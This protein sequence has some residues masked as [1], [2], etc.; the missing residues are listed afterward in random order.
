M[1][2][3]RNGTC[4][5]NHKCSCEGET[6]QLQERLRRHSR[7]MPEFLAKVNR[8]REE[9]LRYIVKEE[10]APWVYMQVCHALSVVLNTVVV[11]VHLDETDLEETAHGSARQYH[12]A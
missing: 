10:T 2:G 8:N 1:R 6:A 5:K 9:K 3:A 7:P 12:T 11:E 4:C